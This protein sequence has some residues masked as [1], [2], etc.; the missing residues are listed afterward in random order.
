[1]WSWSQRQA[2]R[3]QMGLRQMRSR[4]FSQRRMLAGTR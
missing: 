1:V 4:A 2:A 3:W